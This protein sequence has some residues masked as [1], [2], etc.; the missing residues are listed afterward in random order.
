MITKIQLQKD[1]VVLSE[2]G[3]KAGSLERVVVNPKTNV[4]TDIVVRTG[5]LMHN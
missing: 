2:N 1:A 3:K 4:I 5:G